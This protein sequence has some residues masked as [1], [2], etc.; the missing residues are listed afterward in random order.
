MMLEALNYPFMQNALWALLLISIAA[1]IMG[2]LMVINRLVFLAGGIAHAAYAGIGLAVFFSWP[3]LPTTLV[4]SVALATLLTQITLTQSHRQ[5]T[6]IAVIWSTGMAVGI[7]LI[8]ATPGYQADWMS[9][10]FGN[11]LL[12][13]EN[14]LLFMAL[15]DGVI[16]L[17]VGVF[18]RWI[19]STS[20]DPQLAKL[21]GIP[22]HWIKWMLL[23][24]IA[25][26]VV[27]AIR[28]VGLILVLALMSIPAYLA[29]SYAQSLK[30]MMAL[31]SIFALG[32]GL[33][34]LML[35]Y[36]WD[37]PAG[38]SIILVA[39]TALGLSLKGKS[40]RVAGA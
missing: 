22:V 26:V 28:V 5:D 27:M 39:A 38:P 32:F 2:S 11:L 14:D 35:A 33:V 15:M 20:Y 21:Q 37:W 31:A 17:L 7:I 3:L 13:E 10:L 40:L 36:A 8:Q 34:G 30:R 19:L 12:V 23:S 9:Y 25:L 4:V 16:L 29:E 6:W 24:L 1:G 18:F